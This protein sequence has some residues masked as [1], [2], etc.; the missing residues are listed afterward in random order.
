MARLG[1]VVDAEP[2]PAAE[3][4]AEQRALFINHEKSERSFPVVLVVT[5]LRRAPMAFF[6]EDVHR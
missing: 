2:D 3:R 5:H 6:P 1:R 4:K